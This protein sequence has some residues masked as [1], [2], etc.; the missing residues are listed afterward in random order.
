MNIFWI[1]A[2]IKSWCVSQKIYNNKEKKIHDDFQNFIKFID[3][4]I[5]Q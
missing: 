2:E 4:K 5:Y 1:I 3:Y